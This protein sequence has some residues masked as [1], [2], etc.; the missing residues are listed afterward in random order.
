LSLNFG[1]ESQNC[2]ECYENSYAEL[3]Y[4]DVDDG[5]LV[6]EYCY[7]EWD[8]VEGTETAKNN[9]VYVIQCISNKKLNK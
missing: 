4:R 9:Q 7:G 3:I 8:S 1:C 5:V 6:D 2:K